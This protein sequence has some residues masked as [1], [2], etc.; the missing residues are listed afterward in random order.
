MNAVSSHL[1]QL[2]AALAGMLETRTEKLNT[3]DDAA[4]ILRSTICCFAVL[5]V[6]IPLF[7]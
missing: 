4:L 7:H 3:S 1:E 5:L 2:I 6:R